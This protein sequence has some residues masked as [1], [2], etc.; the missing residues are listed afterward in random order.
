MRTIL[1]SV[2][3]ICAASATLPSQER[4]SVGVRILAL[5]GASTALNSE[6]WAT[7]GNPASLGGIDVLTASAFVI[8]GLYGLVELRTLAVCAI[9]PL[10]GGAIGASVS[11]FGFELYHETTVSVGCA[12]RAAR[13][14][15][16]GA[17]MHGSSIAI[18]RYGRRLSWTADLGMVASLFE[19]LWFGAAVRSLWGEVPLLPGG[20][21]PTAVSSGLCASP[22][23]GTL[24]VFELEKEEGFPLIAK[25]GMELLVV[26]ELV[27]RAGAATNP[28]TFSAGCSLRLAHLEFGYAGFHHQDLGWTHALEI[29]FA[30]GF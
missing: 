4:R 20:D 6:A 15:T 11:R 7:N 28:Q 22:R 29:R 13:A 9:S 19:E 12:L 21:L 16:L 25:I 17:T 3:L 2:C 30:G 14:V 27:V 24:L 23:E 10:S 8:P 26:E 5:G 1:I 18:A